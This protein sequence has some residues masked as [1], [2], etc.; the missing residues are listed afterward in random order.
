MKLDYTISIST[1]ITELKY[2][3]TM[4]IIKNYTDEKGLKQGLWE[5][6]RGD[7]SVHSRGEYKD[8]KETGFWEYF[9]EKEDGVLTCGNYINGMKSGTWKGRGTIRA[10]DSYERNFKNGLRNGIQKERIGG[11]LIL[12]FFMVNEKKFGMYNF[13]RLGG[14]IIQRGFY[15]NNKMIGLWYDKRYN[16]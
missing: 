10:D 4:D 13:Y 14:V 15:N 11:D 5:Y 9:Q 7:G 2:N 3:T 12:I 1:M 6:Y 8:N 16:D